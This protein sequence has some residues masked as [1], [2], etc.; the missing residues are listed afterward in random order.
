MA[1]VSHGVHGLPGVDGIHAGE[2]LE[3]VDLVRRGLTDPEPLLVQKHVDL[4]SG[5]L[6][7]V[8]IQEEGE[9]GL[10]DIAQDLTRQ[11]PGC[12]VGLTRL[13]PHSRT[14]SN[15]PGNS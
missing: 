9:I 8:L 4:E 5:G 6:E 2:I 14:S 10:L 15:L 13:R 1:A 11:G 12:T 3:C 7:A